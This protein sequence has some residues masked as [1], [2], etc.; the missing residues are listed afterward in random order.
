MKDV[1]KAK[2]KYALNKCFENK[3]KQNEN[4][5]TTYI[6]T[7]TDQRGGKKKNKI[8][9]YAK[10][11]AFMSKEIAVYAILRIR[12]KLNYPHPL[13]AETENEL[14]KKGIVTFK[15]KTI[16]NVNYIKKQT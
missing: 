16:S 4:K 14:M 15:G 6:I 12:Y 2:Y 11:W 9:V 1:P 5:K 8:L 13:R 7:W 10:E 3:K